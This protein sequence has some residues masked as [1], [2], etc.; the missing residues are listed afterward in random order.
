MSVRVVAFT[1]SGL[2]QEYLRRS[3]DSWAAA[4]GVRDWTF[5][6]VLEPCEKVFPAEAFWAWA[7][8]RFPGCHLLKNG[9]RLG[10]AA[11]TRRAADFAFELGADFAVLAEEDIVVSSDVLEYLDWARRRYRDDRAVAASCAHARRSRGA[12]LAAVVRAPWFSPLVWGTWPEKW[13]GFIR[14]GWGGILDNPEAWDANLRVQLAPAGRQ[15]VFPARSR[16]LHIGEQS[17]FVMGAI[18]EHMYSIS[19]SE[20]FEPDVPPQDYREVPFDGVDRLLV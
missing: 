14:P 16:A 6:F 19:V 18:A 4:R 2:R 8:E 3:L 20:C 9:R 13:Y 1:V 10:C 5:A 17:T 7:R 15:C 11:N 12:D